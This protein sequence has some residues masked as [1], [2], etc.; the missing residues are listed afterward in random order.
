MDI[1]DR[2]GEWKVLSERKIVNK[3]SKRLCKCTCGNEKLVNEGDLKNGKSKRCSKCRIIRMK[4]HP[5]SYKHGSKYNRLRKCWNDMISRCN[6]KNNIAYHRYGG[7]GIKVIKT[8]LN[9]EN[10]KKWALDNGYTNIL[11]L[12]RI[13]N[14]KGYCPNNCRWASYIEQNRNKRNNRRYKCWGI[15]KTIRGWTEDDRC[16]VSFSTLKNRL[17]YDWNIE[18]A[19]TLPKNPGGRYEK[20]R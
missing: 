3:K 9:F 1:N 11:T 15:E 12:D 8:W 14:D 2:F 10:F 19:L 13:N 6:N 18:D 5:P 16:L 7:K 4:T 17:R 20:R